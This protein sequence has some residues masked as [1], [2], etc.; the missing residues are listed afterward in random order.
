MKMQCMKRLIVQKTYLGLVTVD[1][2][3]RLF[4]S[5]LFSVD[6]SKICNASGT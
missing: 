6:C 3:S 5:Q 4:F 1:P 2:S